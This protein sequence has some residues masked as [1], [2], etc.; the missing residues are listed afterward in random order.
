M[1]ASD[2]ES[3]AD[4]GDAEQANNYEEATTFNQEEDMTMVSNPVY[5]L[6]NVLF[7]VDAVGE[8]LE[9]TTALASNWLPEE[10]KPPFQQTATP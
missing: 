9:T 3:R 7:P 5:R 8:V 6:R 4:D 1:A 10:P 2:G